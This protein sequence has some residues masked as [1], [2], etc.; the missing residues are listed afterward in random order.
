MAN[1]GRLTNTFLSW[2]TAASAIQAKMTAGTN[3]LTFTGVGDSASVQLKNVTD[4]TSAQDAATKNYV[5]TVAYG[6]NWHAPVLSA[7]T[8][9]VPQSEMDSP[10]TTFTAYGGVSFTTTSRILLVNQLNPGTLGVQNGIW[11]WTS[12]GV[13][14]Y[15]AI[16][17]TTGTNAAGD[18]MYVQQGSLG[19]ELYIC[20]NDPASATIGINPL[21]FVQFA[22][23]VTQQAA[24]SN[25]FVQYND[26]GSFGA[27]STF[28]FNSVSNTLSVI[29]GTI[30][31]TAFVGSTINV[32]T[33]SFGPVSATSL[34]V[35]GNESVGGTLSVTGT[36]SFTGAM[37]ATS[38]TVS[39]NEAIGGNLVV[40]GTST[41]TGSM[42]ASTASFGPVTVTSLGVSGSVGVGGTLSVTGASTFSGAVTA[43][44]LV[45][46]A[47]DSQINLYNNLS[48]GT[49]TIGT[50]STYTYIPGTLTV[51][52]LSVTAPINFTNLTVTSLTV[53]GPSVFNGTIAANNVVNINSTLN[54]TSLATFGPISAT[55]AT[56]SG[57]LSGTSA[58]FSGA[59]GASSAA[60]GP[61]NA[62]AT[63]LSGAL[64][65]TSGT[66]SSFISATSATLSG[67]LSGTSGSFTGAIGASSAAFGPLSASNATFTGT[68]TATTL[69]GPAIYISPT[70]QG[71]TIGGTNITYVTSGT[72]LG[73]QFL[74]SSQTAI[75][76]AGNNY[77][78]TDFGISY[79]TG[80]TAPA[81]ASTVYIEGAPLG[82]ALTNYALNVASGAVNIG[83]ALTATTASF[84]P[85]TATSLAVSGNASV[86]GTLAV[87]GS[88][89][90]TGQINA[91]SITSTY[92]S[93]TSLSVS[94]PI[95]FANFTATSLTVTGPS[96]FNGT[97]TANSTATFN[98]ST[99]MNGT[100]TVTSQATFNGPVSMTSTLNVTSLA[101]FG[102]ISATSATLSGPLSGTSANFSGAIGA[103]SAAF[104]PLSASNATL[105]GTLSGT[106]ATFSS[107]ISATSATFSGPV[108]GT[109]ANFSG[110]IGATSAAFNTLSVTSI[111]GGAAGLNTQIQFRDAS[112]N[113]AA[114][115]DL[116]VTTATN[117]LSVGV[118]N[119][120]VVA[121]GPNL[122]V[123][124]SS[125]TNSIAATGSGAF[126]MSNTAAQAVN[127]F[128]TTTSGALSMGTALTSTF[129]L[130][131][132]AATTLNT[133][134]YGTTVSVGTASSIVYVNGT[135]AASSSSTGA[136]V[137]SGGVGVSGAVYA[138]GIV[139]GTEFQATSDVQYKTN[140]KKLDDPL[141][142]IKKIEGY[143][144]DWK[145][146]FAGYKPNRNYGLIA[147][148]LEEIGLSDLVAGTTSKSVNYIGVIPF[149]V[150][151]IK[152]LNDKVE[153]LS[154]KK[155]YIITLSYE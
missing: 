121:V 146:S 44:T 118:A 56:L 154:E 155:N 59:I 84:G 82:S 10:T 17:A 110:A 83:G 28:T 128:N 13:P 5:D 37:T 36:S 103:A 43:T 60:F 107:Y 101:T 87:T 114:Y 25:T 130:G 46:P 115:S 131:N 133:S 4:P 124:G 71:V 106:S 42:T 47:T 67:P 152:E 104:G 144:Y 96:V 135:T 54:V 119:S 8:T 80:A 140:I 143:S 19:G 120:G 75:G 145:T 78:F 18:A 62:G 100:L 88:S 92:I 153:E 57:P 79:V 16:D 40:T 64:S 69:T 27:T 29:G 48:A 113:F 148:Q 105:T 61:L 86:G 127:L 139:Y 85:V 74:V 21:T 9:S 81:Q 14:L 76:A 123:T 72:T 7:T 142:M 52:S 20:T 137:V 55:S 125:S 45:A 68:V 6:M 108:S 141:E 102:P 111:L 32:G 89:T 97:I 58:N 151:A 33:A 1:T 35:S 26:S 129:T 98:G 38:V 126:T 2:T 134:I 90:F 50:G 63:T 132:S 77:A 99:D 12:I 150:E 51:T 73:T 95:N 112:G 49:I 91:T 109:S 136:L 117:T 53:T 30:S 3:T 23:I 65:G 138:G 11:I 93:V 41:F 22:S 66:F 70:S 24:G 122:S 34:S 94:A 116:T 15:R 39:G 31:T 149:L 147:Q